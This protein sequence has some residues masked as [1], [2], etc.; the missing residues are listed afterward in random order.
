MNTPATACWHCGAALPADPPVA[1]VAGSPRP[2]CCHG[3]RAAAQWIEGLGLADYYR[4]RDTP[5]ERPVEHSTAQVWARPELARHAVR[6]L[7]DGRSEVCLLVEGLR[8]SACVWLIE[9]GLGTLPGVASVQV[10]ATAQRARVVF[11]AGRATLPQLLLA[12]ERL[13]Y[14]PLPLDARA[15]DDARRHE[16]RAA[17]KGLLVA[18]FGMMQAMMYATAL[19][20]GAFDGMDGATRDLFRW[21]GLLV[22][23]PVVFYAARPF[24]AGARRSLA[25]RRLGMDVPVA[26]AIALIY[27]ASMVETLRGGAEVYFDSVSMFVFFLLLGRHLEMRARHRAA[28]LSDALARLA[29]ACADRVRADG[30]LER[31]G[32]VELVPGDRVH[33]AEGGILPAD[34]RLESERCSVDETLLTGESLP[35]TRQR[36]DTLVAGT[37]L[38]QGP[39][40]LLIERVGADTAL[41]G[42][43]ALV[44]RAQTERPRLAQAGE[45]AAAGFVARVLALA[46][47]TAIGWSLIDPSRAFTATLAVLVVSCPCAFALAVPAALTR[48]LGVLAQRGVLVTRA[49]AIEQLA[50]A[51]HAVFD[52]TGTLTSPE[53]RLERIEPHDGLDREAALR[54]AV[55]LARGSSHPAARAIALTLPDVALPAVDGLRV[56]AGAGVE[57]RVAGRR[58]RLGRADFALDGTRIPAGLE[59]ATVLAGDG[60]LLASFQLSE[61]LRP[62]TRDALD[63]LTADGLAVEIASGDAPGR[64]AAIAATLGIAHWSA[65][66]RPADKL[67]RLTALREAG[68]R[69]IAVGD[70]INDAPVLAGADVAVALASGAQLAQASSDIVL[71]GNR[72]DALAGARQLA[73]Q[74]LA[75]LRQNQ[76]WSLLYNLTAVPFGA[77]G[78]VPPWLA[79]IG[80]SLSS[81]VVVLN[82]LRIGRQEHSPAGSPVAAV[83]GAGA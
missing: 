13:G 37:L 45:R 72:L 3:C 60:R 52:K 44:T 68:A 70:G 47:L 19:Y 77:L 41:A 83:A 4:L 2:V 22:A 31:V 43:V 40:R 38:V 10:N 42:I 9:R 30:T 24:F 46:A 59:E 74:A 26:I 62:G 49:D 14:R 12:L 33:V 5:A 16:S 27:A 28:N 82:A 1:Q 73:R 20:L 63:A 21:V 78:F 65:R 71:V 75:I 23:T 76:R 53:L 61:R 39:A 17:L 56:L 55:A 7:A 57:G 11:D 8:C 58:L 66:Q 15:L 69:V 79:A 18:G 6:I 36:G 80:M 81:L 34:G 25:A 54:L 48:A 64:V 29:P 32:A 35:V 50:T 51:T 67:S